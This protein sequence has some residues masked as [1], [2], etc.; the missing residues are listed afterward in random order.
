MKKLITPIII[1][2]F[3]LALVAQNAT[4][5]APKAD[6]KACACCA[7][8]AKCEDCCKNGCKDCKGADGKMMDCCKGKDGKM[9]CARGTNGNMDC[10]KGMAEMKGHDMSKMGKM[11]KGC[12]GGMC[13][14]KGAAKSGM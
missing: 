12:C 13:D 10:C 14:R 6:T 5:P 8:K 7:D 9:A 2:V 1:L 3:A 4:T 11:G